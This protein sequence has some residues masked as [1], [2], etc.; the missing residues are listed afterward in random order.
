[1]N[2]PIITIFTKIDLVPESTK[3]ELIKSFKSVILR[4][5]LNRMPIVIK[6]NDDIVLFSRNIQEKNIM[7]ICFVSNINWDGLNLLKSFMSMLPVND[8]FKGI[9]ND[10][11]E[12]IKKLIN[13]LTNSYL[14]F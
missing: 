5:K 1:M 13:F 12:V 9:E 7:A 14:I 2:L 6:T 4:L 8:Q 11:I 3:K 10:G